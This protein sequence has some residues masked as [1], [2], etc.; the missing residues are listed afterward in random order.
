MRQSFLSSHLQLE[1][2]YP[3]LYITPALPP[4]VSAGGPG[5][6]L[7]AAPLC[8]T[9]VHAQ[10]SLLTTLFLLFSLKIIFLV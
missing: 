4:A 10:G 7:D 3:E 6:L 2:S 1:G 9:C 5:S 8:A